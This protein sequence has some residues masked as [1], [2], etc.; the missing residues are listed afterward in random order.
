M[1]PFDRSHTR[2]YSPSI[3]TMALSCIVC[4]ILRLIGRKSGNLYTPPVFSAPVGGDPF[5]ISWRCLMLVK[6]EWLS[7]RTVK[8]TVTICSAVFIWYRNVT[9]G[10]A[11]RWTDLIYQYRASVCWRTIK[12]QLKTSHFF[13]YSQRVIHDPHD[14]WRDDT[15]GACHFC[16][17]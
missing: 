15:G 13:V 8:K 2:C 3:V 5:G 6:L 7:Y 10:R 1:A 9:D 11:D 17:R 16:T 14:T 12:K 4:E